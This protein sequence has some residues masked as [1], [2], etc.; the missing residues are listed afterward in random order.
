VTQSPAQ[1]KWQSGDGV[2]S[3]EIYKKDFTL[4]DIPTGG[5]VYIRL[6]LHK[7]QKV[8]PEEQAALF[9]QWTVSE[10]IP[11]ELIAQYD[12][13]G[14]QTTRILN[15][16]NTDGVFKEMGIECFLMNTLVQFL[17]QFMRPDSLV[18]AGMSGKNN[19]LLKRYFEVLFNTEPDEHFDF[20]VQLEDI[21]YNHEAM[22]RKYP[23]YVALSDFV[24][25]NADEA[26][27]DGH[28]HRV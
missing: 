18:M 16:C 28:N 6:F 14:R 2:L 24:T 17:N 23:K 4:G 10:P 22:F 5:S 21:P 8:L 12:L 25:G 20:T 3:A 9:S 13:M 27:P 1:L 15:I 7:P 26:L 11:F 19:V